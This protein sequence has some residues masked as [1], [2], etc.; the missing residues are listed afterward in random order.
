MAASGVVALMATC[1]TRGASIGR[2]RHRV[3]VQVVSQVVDGAGGTTDTWTTAS[4]VWAAIEPASARDVERVFGAELHA[5]ITHLVTMRYLSG[6]THKHRLLF[7]SR[8]LQI[9]GMQNPDERNEWWIVA[10]EELST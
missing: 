1:A 7:G 2:L 8:V 3:S 10:A 4:T 6:L 5:P 9:R